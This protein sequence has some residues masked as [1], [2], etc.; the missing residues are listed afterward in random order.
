[1]PEHVSR[2]ITEVMAAQDEVAARGIEVTPEALYR[3]GMLA[4][5][6][7]EYEAAVGYFRQATQANPEFTDAYAAITWL[8]QS[9]AMHDIQVRDYESA[10]KKLG[11]AR[12][13]AR[14]TDP[15]DLR[16]LTLRGYLSKTMAQIAG[17]R[18]NASERATYYEEAGR[19][20]NHVVGLAP[21]DAGAHNGLGNV[22]YARGDLDGAIAAY[23]RAIAL[24]PS[25]TAAYN[26]LALAYEGKMDAEPDQR[27][28]WCRE[29][30]TAWRAAYRLA[31]NDPGFSERNVI[32]IGR[33]ILRLEQLCPT[34]E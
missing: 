29:A 10:M 34:G 13:A 1:V 26:D 14:H 24:A 11:E 28:A 8:Q 31:P 23:C 6:Q 7:R 18:G 27:G 25:Y 33:R 30:L 2:Q 9:R 21:D 32:T 5:H 17:L 15:L 20:F 12:T 22:A 16:A 4:A 19:F 3:L